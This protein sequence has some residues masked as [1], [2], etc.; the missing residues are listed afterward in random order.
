MPNFQLYDAISRRHR[1]FPDLRRYDIDAEFCALSIPHTLNDPFCE[2]NSLFFLDIFIGKMAHFP[3][4]TPEVVR[5]LCILYDRKHPL[6]VRWAGCRRGDLSSIVSR[7][8]MVAGRRW[9]FF[10]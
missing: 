3:V 1:F 6:S 2:T 4:I 10:S 9:S 5:D 8:R 7:Y